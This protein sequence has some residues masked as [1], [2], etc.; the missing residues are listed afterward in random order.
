MWVPEVSR[1]SAVTSSGAAS[2]NR[3]KRV[4]GELE[5]GTDGRHQGG[6]GHDGGGAEHEH[7]FDVK[8]LINGGS[9]VSMMIK[10]T[11]SDGALLLSVSVTTP[12]SGGTLTKKAAEAVPAAGSI[13]RSSIAYWRMVGPSR[14]SDT[15]WS[16]S[17]GLA[18][19]ELAS[20]WPPGIGSV[21]TDVPGVQFPLK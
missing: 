3:G 12:S 6:L 21:S 8:P 1:P 5:H 15:K 10:S 13:R 14:T 16:V 11:S 4:V 7:L 20:P 2:A 17:D 18:R 9:T 19:L